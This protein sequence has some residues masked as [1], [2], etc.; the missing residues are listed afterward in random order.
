[1]GTNFF[2]KTQIGNIYAKINFV[3]LILLVRILVIKNVIAQADKS[4][5]M[6]IGKITSKGELIESA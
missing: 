4:C 6:V 2:N 5:V 3:N 1:M